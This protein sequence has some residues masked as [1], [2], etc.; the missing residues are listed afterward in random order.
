ML[1]ITVPPVEEL[2]DEARKEFM[3]FDGCTLQLEHS[4][5][6][7]SKWES[8]HHKAFL[9]NIK[10]LTIDEW[11]SYIQCMTL[12]K[13]VN[14]LAYFCLTSQNYN[15][16]VSYINDPM[17]AAWFDNRQDN[18]PGRKDSMV[19]EILY[20]KMIINGIPFECERW[21][22]NRLVALIRVCDIKSS[23][24]KK[25]GSKAIINKYAALNEMRKAMWHTK[26]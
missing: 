4:L 15:D 2:W 10:K 20:Y 3:H 26:G 12:N 5:I 11:R 21:H 18:T 17:T 22:L 1:P 19:S 16:I 9:E 24:D 23:P 13:K 25:V 8:I 14:P 7:I 6:S